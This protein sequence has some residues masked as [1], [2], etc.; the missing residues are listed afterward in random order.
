M[1]RH[2]LIPALLTLALVLA[3]AGAALGQ[4]AET[5]V[6]AGR[7][8]D[9]Q[10]SALPGVSVAASRPDGS[11]QRRAT[12]DTEGRFRL[13]FLPPGDYRLTAGLDGFAEVQLVNLR[14][15]AANSTEIE[16]RLLPADTVSEEI[17]VTDA[18]PLI[19]TGSTDAG[20]TLTA[21]ELELLPTFRSATS[22]VAFTAGARPDQVWGGSTTQ[23]NAYQLDGVGVNNPGFGGD[24]L[25]PNV[26][27]IEEIE[28]KGLGA[29]AEYGNF[30]GGL[31]NLVTKSGGNELTG[32]VRLNWE[33]E[34]INSSNVNALEAGEERD[35][36]G[37]VSADVSGPILRDRLYYFISA[38]QARTD[39]RIVDGINS[40]A[41]EIA[42]LPVQEERTETKLYGKLNWDLTSS[43]RLGF[44][45]IWDD[46]QTDNRDL[47]S[48][49]AAEAA[50]TQESPAFA[51]SAAWQ[52]V[53]GG[54][55]FLEVKLTGYDGENDRTPLNGD[56]PAVQILGG[57]R[58]IFR[59]ALYTREQ[60]LESQALTAS[61]DRLFSLGG[62]SHQIKAGGSHERGSWLEQRRR[63]GGYTWR[64]EEGSGPFDPNDPATWGFISSDWGGRIRL[65]AESTNSAVFVQDNVELG[66]RL[67]LNLGLRY[68]WWTGDLTP[69]LTGGASFEAV[70]TDG[71]DPRIGLVFDIDGKGTLLGKAHWGRYHQSL[72]ALMYDR[73]IGGDVFEDLEYWDWIGPGLP[74]L[75]RIY[76]EADRARFFEFFDSDPTGEEV[77]RV[78]GFEQPYVDQLVLSLE[79]A[80]GD[81]KVALT[82]VN[83]ENGDIA[84][85][86]D[87]NLWDNYTAFYNVEV[88]DFRSGDPVLDA[89]G[90][91]LVLPVLYL[92]NDDIKRRGSAP[93]LTP[94]QIA[95]LNYDPDYVLTSEPSAVREFDQ[96]QLSVDH[97]G[98]RWRASA[99]LVWTEL[100]G[101]F[102]SVSGYDD[103]F[104]TGAGA[105]VA[106]NEQTNFDGKLENYS[107][108]ELK[109]RL[110]GDLV[111]GLRGG[112][113]ANFTRG[114]F[115]APTYSIDNRNHDFY[116]ANGAYFNFRLING[117]N[118]QQI[119]LEE[120]GSREFEDY[121]VVDVY[122]DRPFKIGPTELVVSLDVFNLFDEDAVVSVKQSVNNQI[123][124]DPTTLFGAPR[125][126]QSARTVRLGLTLRF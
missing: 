56:I 72:F 81:T 86:V 98:R 83:R 19:D 50:T 59:N 126:R 77:G 71:F 102:F 73:A 64:P 89:N 113:F 6:L 84:A 103:P 13:G 3:P 14:V 7:V 95:G 49:T 52:K 15:S 8:V 63:N 70:S 55:S 30:Q 54:S 105:F 41:G 88:I 38:Q 25:L 37:E 18:T 110:S 115:Y 118:G 68:G 28:V 9:A 87:R 82:Y 48:F 34:S 80:F 96:L 35:S 76:T 31:I 12:T 46:V 57:N 104:G 116:A 124:G 5:G 23:A 2:R 85:L 16:I 122:L 101:N 33:D 74:D 65:D 94:A 125:L 66:R 75:G 26:D 58:D 114:D 111:W 109:L 112:L 119:L 99:S 120:R 42:F 4:T 45:L 78:E 90:N 100:T 69:G 67:K 51:Y 22:L 121:S 20:S 27:W 39:T 24:F 91:P 117:V 97:R 60:D 32:A 43:D 44:V 1:P 92:R 17:T 47:D 93:G 108:W 29:G 62:T 11:N 10:G 106:L 36:R 40:S 79:K 123:P 21:A 53:I 61:F 107:E